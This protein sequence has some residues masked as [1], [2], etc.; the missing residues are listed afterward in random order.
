MLSGCNIQNESMGHFVLLLR[1]GTQ[2]FL[3]KLTCNT[4]TLDVKVGYPGGSVQADIQD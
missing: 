3:K 4:N 1:E 2:I